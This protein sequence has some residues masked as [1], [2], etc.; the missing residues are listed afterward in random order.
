MKRQMK[1]ALLL[2]CGATLTALVGCTTSE[3]ESMQAVGINV[4]PMDEQPAQAETVI[5][6][7]YGEEEIG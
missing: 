5:L 1:T 6:G 3:V 7:V 2:A 4:T